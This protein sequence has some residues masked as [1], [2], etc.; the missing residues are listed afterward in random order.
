M[1][2]LK[3][4]KNFNYMKNLL[5]LLVCSI[6]FLAAECD[7]SDSGGVVSGGSD[8][9]KTAE[10][11]AKLT[12]IGIVSADGFGT[13]AA[14]Y[15]EYCSGCHGQKVEAFTDQIRD[16]KHG[17]SIPEITKSISEGWEDAGM[18]GYD[19][20][21]TEKQIADLAA[22]L[23]EGINVWKSLEPNDAAKSE[24]MESSLGRMRLETVTNAAEVPWG[25]DFLPDNS[26]LVTDRDGDFYRIENNG[27]AI[28]IGNVP[29]VFAENQGGLL[30]VEIHPA[31]AEN[32][33]I[34][35]SYSK[36]QKGND[37]FSTT[38]IIRAKLTGDVLTEITEI[39]EAKPY[40]KTRHHYGCRMEFD[41]DGYL[42]FAVGD[43]GKR[44]INPQ[45]LDNDCGKIH[46][47]H[48]DGR[49]PTDN[50]FVKTEGAHGSIWSYGHRNP[51][52]LVIDRTTGTVWE[53]E[54]G[55]RGGDE[56]NLI[57][58]G[59]NYG[60]PLISYGINYNGT[61]FTDK[62][63]MPG[64]KSPETYYV[65]SIAPSGLAMI[66]GDKYGEWEGDLIAGSLR[67]KYLDRV[68]VKD[69]LVLDRTEELKNIGRVREVKM[70]N[71]GF[72]YVAVEGE[73]GSV[74]RL[75]PME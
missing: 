37:G 47:V 40:F 56:V 23:H 38:A 67:F 39:F 34:Y 63:T 73:P 7:S 59:K 62:T 49:I 15:K 45:K 64:M 54:H 28:K 74:Y 36:P 3:Q 24:I 32:G 53:H 60:W 52:G 14:D 44:D 30:D 8:T 2:P 13:A 9:V 17:T 31:F 72:L 71:D 16:W 68:I 66:T 22:Y 35:L 55:P 4:F 43:R 69:D 18:P 21:F 20:V 19:T 29:K 26:M 27:N 11:E 33:F 12:K 70:G 41:N 65:P 57:E 48:D 61:T 46:R 50:P 10:K 51:Q 75:M 1:L 25:I 5:F 42:F 6:V 58:K